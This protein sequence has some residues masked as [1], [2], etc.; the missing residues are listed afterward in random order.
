MTVLPSEF[1]MKLHTLSYVNHTNYAL[2]GRA[3]AV[4]SL[5]MYPGSLAQY[6]QYVE[7]HDTS[8]TGV[9]CKIRKAYNQHPS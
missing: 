1:K 6:G 5:V 7:G 4:P 9:R 3:R 8:A 2:A